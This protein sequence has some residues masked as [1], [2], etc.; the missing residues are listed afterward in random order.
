ML[1]NKIIKLI[2]TELK[3]L[4]KTDLALHPVYGINDLSV[5]GQL[6]STKWKIVPS[7][8]FV[9]CAKMSR[10]CKCSAHNTGN[11]CNPPHPPPKKNISSATCRHPGIGLKVKV[12]YV[13]IFHS[14]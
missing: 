6:S 3:W 11:S 13:K 8:Y 14:I 5:H 9:S 12:M 1:P 2:F 10:F 4:K 7:F